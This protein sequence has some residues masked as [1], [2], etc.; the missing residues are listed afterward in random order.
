MSKII[1]SEDLAIASVPAIKDVVPV[2]SQILIEI[3]T[4]QEKAG[5]QIYVGEVTGDPENPP[6]AYVLKLGPRVSPD[7]GIKVGDRVLLNGMGSFVPRYD[8][9]KRK[10]LLVEPQVIKAVLVE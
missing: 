8:N 9:N 10:R 2:L 5:T 7:F 1:G 4:D 6:Q 3:L